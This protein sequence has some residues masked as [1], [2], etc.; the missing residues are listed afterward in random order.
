[1]KNP[2]LPNPACAQCENHA[3]SSSDSIKP[4]LLKSLPK[5]LILSISFLLSMGAFAQNISNYS[6]AASGS[7]FTALATPVNPVISGGDADN[8]YFNAL[9]IGFDFWYMGNRYTS[10]SASTNGWFTFGTNITDA[11]YVNNLSTGTTRPIVAPLWDDISIVTASNFSYKTTGTAG[12]RIFTLQWLSAKWDYSA[13]SATMSFQARLSEGTGKIEFVYQQV[14][15]AA[16][17][18][19]SASIG[20]AATATGSGNYISLSSSSATP[21]VNTTTETNTIS[22]KPANGQLYSF[23]APVPATPSALVFSA[24]GNTGMTLNWTDNASNERGYAIYLSTDGGT[25]YSFV[26]QAAANASSSV[27]SGLTPNTTYF[28]KVYAVTE[29]ALSTAVSGSQLTTCTAPATPSVTSPVNYCLG[30]TAAQLSA[31]GSNLLWTTAGAGVAGGTSA[32]TTT[33]YVDAGGSNKK[34]NFTTTANNI[35]ISK[36]DYYIPAYQAVNSLVLGIYNASG[37][38]LATSSTSTTQ[39]AGA[40]SVKITSIFNYNIITSGNYSIGIVSGTGNIGSDNPVFPVTEPTGIINITGVT[41]AGVRCFNNIIFTGAVSATAPTPVAT[42]AGNTNYYVTQTVGGCTSAAA[43][44]AVNVNVPNI[45]QVLLTNNIGYYKFEGNANDV[46]N[47][48]NGT[49]Q[50]APTPVANRF[51]FPGT[52]YLFDGSS[53]YVSTANSYLNPPNFTISIWFKTSSVTGGKLI[54][55]GISQTGQSGQYDRHIYMNNAGQLYFGVYPGS[56][57]TVNSTLAYNDGNWHHAAAT[58][59]STAGMKLYIDGVQVAADAATTT[60]ENYRGYWRIGYDNNNG[61]TSQPSSFYFNGSLDDALIYSTALSAAEVSTLYVS[62]DGAGN[63]GPVCTGSAITLSATTISGATYAW[64]GPAGFSSAAQNPSLTFSSAVAGMYTLQVT[65]AGCTATAYTNVIATTNSGQWTGNVSTDWAVAGNWCTG[66]VPTAT[67]NVVISAAATRMP[68]IISSV[69]CNSLTISAG[70]TLTMTSAGTLNIAGTLTNSGTFANSGTTNFNGTSGQQTFSGLST[71]YDLTVSNSSG[72][73]LPNLITVNN[74]LISTGSLNANNFNV[75]VNGNWTNNASTGGFTAATST[76][77]FAGTT[78]QTIGGSFATTFNNLVIANTASRVTLNVNIAVSGSL[79]V[80]NGIFDLAAFTANRVTAGG[81]ITVANN[82]TLKIGGTNTFP[83]NYSLN[84][85]VV[86]STVEY[87]GT[88]QTV[89]G[90]PYGNL[91]LSSSSG[92]AIK[93]FPA[94]ALTIAGNLV[95]ALGSGTSVTYTATTTV[96]VNG[97]VTIG[98]S[99]TFN[100]GGS[101]HTIGGNWTNDG[102]FNGNTGTISFAGPG[103]Q[104]G[105]S[106]VQNFTNLNVVASLVNFANSAIT[107]AGNLTTTGSGSFNQASGGTLTM[108]GSGKAINGSGISLYNLAVTGVITSLTS[109]VIAGNLSVSGTLAA[110]TGTIS[111]SGVTKTISGAGAKSFSTLSITGSITTDVNFSISS[112]LTVIGTFSATAGTATF[113]ST[114]SLS[115]TANLFNTT[116]NGTSLQLSSNSVLGIANVLT[117]T[118]G[119]LN[120]TSSTPNTV[121]FNGSGAQNINAITYNN[122]TLSNGSNKTA[123]AGVTVN[124]SITISSGTTFIP[125]A[126]THSIY[127][128]W[129]NYGTFN[130]GTSTI[131]FLGNQNSNINGATTFNILTVNNAT[132]ATGIILQNDISAATVNMLLGTMLTGANTITITTT[133]TGNG[134]ILGNIKRTHAFTTG[135]AYAF[136]GPNNTIT[137]SAVS[138][139]TSITVSVVPGVVSDFPYGSCISRVYNIVVPAGT[140]TATLRLH[141]EDN[142]LNGNLEAAMALWNYDGTQWIPVG[143]T[144]NSSTSNYVE[145][146][147]LTNITNRW[148]CS[149]NP[150]VVLWN[151]SVSTNWNDPANWTVYVGSGST[152]PSASDVVVL[153]GIAFNYQPSI[154]SAVTVKNLVFGTTQAVTLSMASGG[155][156]TSGDM[157]GVWSSNVSHTINTNSQSI[158]VNGDLALSDGTSGHVINL[159]IGSGTVNVVGSITQS[160]GANVIF[161]GAGNLNIANDYNYVS[162]TFTPLTGTVTYNGIVNQLIGPVNYNNLTINNAAASPSINN[163]TSI[164]GNLTISAGELDN[165][166]TTTIA[167]NV[168]IAAGAIFDN[169]GIL[170][171]GGNWTNNGNYS[172]NGTNVFFDGTGTQTISATTF[173]NIIINKPVGSTAML[174]GN[175]VLNGDLTITSGTFDIKTFDCNRS[176]QGG[177]ITLADSATFIIGANNSPLNF[178]NGTLATSSTVIANGTGPQFIFGVDFG[179]IVFRNAGAKTLVA[180]IT[181]KGDLTIEAGSNFDAGS[182]TLTLGGNWINNGI[183]VPSTSTVV[184]TGAS[185]SF[186]GNSTFKR[187]SIYGSYTFLSNNTIDSL[188][189]INPAGSLSGGSGITTTMNGD[190]VNKGILYALGTTTFTGN[191]VQTLSLINAVQTVAITVNFNGTVSPVLISTSAPQ[192][193]FLNINNT[194]G[195]NPSVGWTVA[196]GLTVGAGASFN[197]GISSHFIAG[198]LTNNGTITSSGTLTFI[199]SSSVTVNMGNAFTST[200]RVYFAGT[201]AMTIA[202]NPVSFNNVNIVNTNIAGITPSS[203]WNMTG[204]LTVAAGARLN[205]GNHTYY[206]GG[207]IANRGTINSSTSTFILNGNATQDIYN[208]SA[209]NNLTINKV[210]GQ[211]TLSADGTVNGTLNFLSGSIATGNYSIVIPSAGNVTGAS[212][213]TG[214]VNGN[215]NR[216]I[217]TGAATKTFEVGDAGYYTPVNVAF[218]QV[219]NAGTLTI[220]TTPGDHPQISNSTIN[221]GLTVNRYW[222]FTNNGMV[223]TMYNARFNYAS[224]DLDAGTNTS[225]FGIGNYSG[226]SWTTVASDSANPTSIKAMSVSNMGDF[227]IGDICNKNTSIAY[228]ASPYCSGAG[229]ATVTLTGNTGGLFTSSA[230]LAINASTGLVDISS[231]TAGIYLVSYKL[232]ATGGCPTFVTNASIEITPLSTATIS[233][234]GSP[235]CLN[236]GNAVVN[237]AGT[238]GGVY[239]STSG[240]SINASTGEV[241]T[242]LS[243]VGTYTVTYTIAAGACPLYSTMAS[244]SIVN[245]GTW[246]GAVNNDWD[247]A[248]NWL[249]GQVPTASTNVTLPSG[250]PSYP[251]ITLTRA[252]HD[253][254]IQNGAALNV[255]SGN[256]QVGGAITNAGVF[257][258]SAGTVELNGNSLQTIPAGAFTNNTIMNMVVSND[259]LLAGEDTLTGTLFF[260]SSNKNLNT[261]NHLTLKSTATGTARIDDMTNAGINSGNTIT[262]KINIERYVPLR[263]AWRL[264]SAPVKSAT[265]PT[266]NAAWQE[267]VTTASAYPNPNPGYGVNITGGTVANGFDQSP[268]NAAS[269]KIFNNANNTFTA[270][271]AIP[272][273][274]RPISDYPGYFLYVRG[275]R[276]INLMQGTSAAITSTTLRITGE[277]NCGTQQVNVNPTNFTLLGNPYASAMNF[278]TLTRTNVRNSFYAWDP[279]LSGSFG[280]GAYVAVIWNNATGTYDATASVTP[281]S[282]YIP[283]GEAILVQSADGVSTG[284]IDIKETDKTA[285]GGGQS[286]S[287]ASGPYQQLRVNLYAINTDSS[288]SLL[289]GILT[290][291]SDD[292]NNAVDLDDARK[293]FGSSESINLK[294]DAATLAIE[295]RK[296]ITAADTSFMNIYQMK[297][298]SYRFEIKADNMDH[299]GLTAVIRDSYSNTINNSPLDLNGNTYVDFLVNSDT[300]SYSVNRFRIE[301]KMLAPVPVTFKTIKAYQHEKDIAVEWSTENETNIRQYEVEKS[302]DSRTFNAI[303]S[304]AAVGGNGGNASYQVLDTNPVEGDNYYRVRSVSNDGTGSYTNIVKVNMKK[305]KEQPSL[306]VY[307]N[308][309]SGNMIAMEWSRIPAGVYNLQLY[310]KMGQLFASKTINHTEGSNLETFRLMEEIPAGRYELKL[311]GVNLAITKP[312]LKQ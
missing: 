152:P 81:V 280:L 191:V 240:L 35:S 145:Q 114:S 232:D 171:V 60:A 34:M 198:Y 311:T 220:K 135:V 69:V 253:I 125:G 174:T 30:A 138:A 36:A 77:T 293:M 108:T 235:Y 306:S 21:T 195:V 105:G 299:S 89:A 150:N 175:I 3:S 267:G 79:S 93:T 111:M 54:G 272:G 207:D 212:S 204:N 210:G 181:V 66:V 186:F 168:T 163:T 227:E 46:G 82:A 172:A 288:A 122:L 166:S 160:G 200:G 13:T 298:Q 1:M 5:A 178:A 303:A 270:L 294:R 285:N 263:K 128:D 295:R 40:S 92:A 48:N 115:G 226:S 31:S 143:K 20:I 86:A 252:V 53:Q 16:L 119:T 310:N 257:N 176:V 59:S 127:N 106:G 58:L 161:T 242:S 301:F 75:S 194:G 146:S 205:A 100:A 182:Q 187:L 216:Y 76:V 29:G 88:N 139:V 55:F 148:S 51:G 213:S 90:K 162:G 62:P 57:H 266:I 290:T 10:V 104:V 224:T 273:T 203:D 68:S 27:Q 42:T 211:T 271:P 113:T 70:A 61:W 19:A 44:I 268:N 134:I 156:L 269:I 52:A 6:F 206:A 286:F 8:G 117:I 234:T 244:I 190:L 302:T 296:T 109:F 292:N 208:P 312:V 218:A 121:N 14:G 282:K 33:S 131:Q 97:N 63:N 12:S 65:A 18:S 133:R 101:F 260:H 102:T 124:N 103:A 284:R 281:I 147:G 259:V 98:A 173:N 43:I 120:V 251:L 300:A 229:T 179:N 184:C 140:Y 228:T 199:P 223:Y 201:G 67:S 112:A 261:G 214:W 78:A 189:V 231:S 165:N 192:F 274:M 262:G 144:A 71:F 39:T 73:L 264:L 154:S 276:S 118:S 50:N 221:P 28:W 126:F 217:P 169:H 84:T 72:V 95:S 149:F 238:T 158:T 123:V 164:S 130:A 250:Q 193:G 275:D 2:I 308:P 230:G 87:S 24:V 94:V 110:S 91:T 151:G 56:V 41:T 107:V 17:T 297:R 202:G 236:G 188:L 142:E 26:S 215:L 233:Y 245:P 309:I 246:T 4:F 239:S 219:T 141:Y 256:L 289:D 155:S 170:H 307:P 74:L 47:N 185:K 9:P 32:L 37:T 22:T 209:F 279:Q 25:T 249:C 305:Q 11:F 23:T 183:F 197:G 129:N 80:T 116:I 222:T 153:G 265:S 241:N 304:T 96:N 49:L 83:T 64:S 196:Y 137:F 278:E 254:T 167:G 287:R 38:L 247:N 45:S 248:G 258:V 132:S 255:V 157:I 237:F 15:V 180:P 136:E 177:T 291:Y 283:S 243:A 7:T 99:T 85:L 225:S 159:N 277:A